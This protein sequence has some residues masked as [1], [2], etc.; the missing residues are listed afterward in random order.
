MK[1]SIKELTNKEAQTVNGGCLATTVG[2]CCCE[3]IIWGSIGT[4]AI[5]A[6]AIAAAISNH[7]KI[8]KDNTNAKANTIK[9]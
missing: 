4:I 9:K 8:L 1:S 3:V 2:C 6:T 7:E 5:F